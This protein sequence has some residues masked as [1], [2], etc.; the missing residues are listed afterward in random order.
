[1][2]LHWGF[3]NDSWLIDPIPE[4]MPIRFEE[5]PNGWKINPS[6]IRF[7][8]GANPEYVWGEGKLYHEVLFSDLGFIVMPFFYGRPGFEFVDS[9]KLSISENTDWLGKPSTIYK[10]GRAD[11]TQMV[12]KQIEKFYDVAE[13]KYFKAGDLSSELVEADDATVKTQY[14]TQYEHIFDT[15]SD[16]INNLGCIWYSTFHPDSN[17]NIIDLISNHTINVETPLDKVYFTQGIYENTLLLKDVRIDI[18][19]PMSSIFND[20][21]CNEFFITFKAPANFRPGTLIDY[22]SDIKSGF[23]IDVLKEGVDV[24]VNGNKYHFAENLSFISPNSFMVYFKTMNTL[25]VRINDKTIAVDINEDMPTVL[26]SDKAYLSSYSK[27]HKYVKT[28]D[29]EELG[30]FKH[31]PIESYIKSYMSFDTFLP[32]SQPNSADTM[33]LLLDKFTYSAPASVFIPNSFQSKNSTNKVIPF[34]KIYI[35][36]NNSNVNIADYE[37]KPKLDGS[38]LHMPKDNNVYGAIGHPDP[39]FDDHTEFCDMIK[40]IST[41]SHIPIQ[42]DMKFKIPKW[43]TKDMHLNMDLRLVPINKMAWYAYKRYKTGEWV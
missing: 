29:V 11:V 15:P 5:H 40:K 36:D 25:T 13:D 16:M 2:R 23:R 30:F 7:F 20:K 12:K 39:D 27:S 35:K 32:F 22:G 4:T 28:G 6:S 1:M 21:Q 10:V 31:A 14:Q 3:Y 43:W 37:A 41:D 42:V 19:E 34:E 24:Y 26:E 38:Y 9:F 17:M 8:F 33:P 18:T